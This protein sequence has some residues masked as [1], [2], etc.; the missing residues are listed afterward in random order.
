[1]RKNWLG[2]AEANAVRHGTRGVFAVAG[3]RFRAR[4]I[5]PDSAFQDQGEP[6]PGHWRHA[7]QPW[8]QA[9][10]PRA[11]QMLAAFEELPATWRRVLLRHDGRTR[12]PAE[13][14]GLDDTVAGELGL[15]VDQERDILTQARAAL[16]DRLARGP[17]SGTR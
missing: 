1:M 9:A 11:A 14:A 13:R 4:P 16:R 15:T 7:P 3:R 5:V 2:R 17:E 8:P 12:A 10:R 6:Y